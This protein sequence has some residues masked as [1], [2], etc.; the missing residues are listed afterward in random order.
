MV[1]KPEALSNVISG[2]RSLGCWGLGFRGLGVRGLG[3]RGVRLLGL[4]GFGFRGSGICS[5]FLLTS[6]KALVLRKM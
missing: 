1:S 3:L 5:L 6:Q 4:R 2:F